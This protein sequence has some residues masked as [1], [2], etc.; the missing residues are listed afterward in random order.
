MP[1]ILNRSR[2]PHVQ[3]EVG[4]GNEHCKDENIYYEKIDSEVVKV[5][6]F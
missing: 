1:K 4:I 3:T 2:A 6:G 5:V